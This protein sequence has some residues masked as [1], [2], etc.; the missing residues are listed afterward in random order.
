M[1]T[2]TVILC[3]LTSLFFFVYKKFTKAKIKPIEP[4]T[5]KV[6]KFSGSCYDRRKAKRKLYFF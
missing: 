2:F 4:T 6:H 3:I 1:I 5:E